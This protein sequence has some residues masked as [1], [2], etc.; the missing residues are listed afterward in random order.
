MKIRYREASLFSSG[1]SGT[2]ATLILIIAA[3][4][5][6][7]SNT[8]RAAFQFDDMVNIVENPLVNDL[9]TF[10]SSSYY[11]RFIG[12]LSFA[13]DHQLFG[14]NVT[15]YHAVNLFIHVITTLLVYQ[16]IANISRAP[17]AA[18]DT[19]STTPIA[20]LATLFFALHPLQTQAVTYIV[21]RFTS[22]ATLF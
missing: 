12:N 19:T 7:Y 11:I 6:A 8:F 9:G 2:T 18:Q 15:G 13:L 16:L 20:T 10:L 22:L 21:Q 14:V 4:L 1:F 5:C 3:V 17:F